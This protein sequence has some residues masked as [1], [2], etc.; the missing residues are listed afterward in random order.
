MLVALLALLVVG[1]G[2]GWAAGAALRRDPAPPPSPAAR[3]LTLGALHVRVDGAG[4][5][6]NAPRNAAPAGARAFAT[7]S[8]VPA[9]V[10]L[11]VA[12]AR[13]PTLV[14]ASL[15]KAAD[16]SLGRPGGARLAGHAAW[17]YRDLQAGGDR[18]DLIVQPTAAGMLLVGCQA[19]ASW[20]PLGDGCAQHV[21]AVRGSAFIVPSAQLAFEQALGARLGRL[22]H[23]RA[24]GG[25]QL[26]GARSLRAVARSARM[27][28]NAHAAAARPLRP[29]VASARARR[30]V[31]GLFAVAAGY[32]S[33]ARAAARDARG[34]YARSRRALLRADR[35]LG[36]LARRSAQST[37]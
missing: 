17:I 6:V 5:A 15:R 20:W 12:P 11:A 19:P 4:A 33:L 31:D 29:V 10:W 22:A 28:A 7:G 8:G 2:A 13:D 36:R 26:R 37:R 14:P 25:R 3:W 35:T 30:L 23:A 16:R 9:T 24:A 27:L 32:R 1:A 18:L 34:R 21:G